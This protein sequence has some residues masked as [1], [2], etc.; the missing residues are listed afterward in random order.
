[1]DIVRDVLSVVHAALKNLRQIR[2]KGGH[3]W[4]ETGVEV[5]V[6]I[7]Q[8]CEGVVE[9][10]GLPRLHQHCEERPQTHATGGR[11]W[12]VIAS[13]VAYS[14][15]VLLVEVEA[16]LYQELEGGRLHDILL[17]TQGHDV[18]RLD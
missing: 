8:V 2:D 3:G 17:P 6:Q 5:L 12:L 13:V 18:V 10:H 9:D 14:T 16:M 7:H 15:G 1:M 11:I 4:W